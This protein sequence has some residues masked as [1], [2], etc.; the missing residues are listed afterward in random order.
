MGMEHTM[1]SRY[2]QH[3]SSKTGSDQFRITISK[4]KI[5]FTTKIAPV[6]SCQYNLDLF[7]PSTLVEKGRLPVAE[8]NKFIHD[9]IKSGKSILAFLKLSSMSGSEID[10]YKKFYK[11]YESLGKILMITVLDTTK[12]FLI[13]PK[14]QRAAKCLN[15]NVVNLSRSSTYVVVL[16][17]ETLPMN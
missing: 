13:T 15:Q 8:F 12:A 9:K 16:T 10:S 7:L 3:I 5:S 1:A 6:Q 14:F 2:T 4:L 17:K 11:E